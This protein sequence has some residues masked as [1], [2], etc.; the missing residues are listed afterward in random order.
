M[1]SPG[2]FSPRIKQRYRAIP[3]F[4]GKPTTLFQQPCKPPL[5]SSL[6]VSHRERRRHVHLNNLLGIRVAD[7]SRHSQ[8]QVNANSLFLHRQTHQY[9][10]IDALAAQMPGVG[11]S[12]TETLNRFICQC[13]DDQHRDLMAGFSFVVCKQGGNPIPLCWLQN[14][15][16]I[17]HPASQCRHRRLSRVDHAGFVPG[18]LGARRNQNQRK[19]DDRGAEQRPTSHRFHSCP[20]PGCR[21]AIRLREFPVWYTAQW[22]A[23]PRCLLGQI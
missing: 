7:I 6:K 17:V 20:S 12:K 11:G 23:H 3:L 22:P 8:S 21:S 19:Q 10:V 1:S 5:E 2:K 16:G 14:S 15:G 18:C 4:A 13:R 9:S